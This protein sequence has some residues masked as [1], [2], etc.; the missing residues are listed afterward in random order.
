V[1]TGLSFLLREYKVEDKVIVDID[2][3]Q[4]KGMPHRRFQGRVGT[5]EEI[6]RRSLVISIPVGG[7]VKKV[8]ARLEHVK[9]YTGQ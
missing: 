7:K 4:I 1:K 9:P 2:P 6:G 5:V 8:A 3:K